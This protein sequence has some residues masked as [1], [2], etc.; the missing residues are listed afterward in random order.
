[1]LGAGISGL[2]AAH[3]LVELARDGGGPAALELA[4]FEAACR[5]G[6]IVATAHPDGL[7]LEDGPDA[8]ITDKPEALALCERIGLGPRLIATRP[9][10]RRSAVVFGRRLVPTPAGFHLLAPARLGPLLASP[11]LSLPGRLRAALEPWLPPRTRDGVADE[12]LASFVTRRLG[13]EVLERLAQP[14][15]G[16]IYGA[17]PEELSLLATFP[18]FLRLE[19][20]HG[21]VIRGLARSDRHARVA[22]SGPRY[23]LF[24][25]LQGGMQELADTLAARL[26]PG[27]LRLGT[28]VTGLSPVGMGGWTVVS[29][30]GESRFDAVVVAL[31]APAAGAL[32]AGFDAALG[33]ALGSLA[34]GSSAVVT[35]AFAAGDLGHPRDG[36]GF[37][38]PRRERMLALGGSFSDRKFEG[39]A[40]AGTA[41]VRVFFDGRSDGLDDRALAARAAAEAGALLQLRAG[42]APTSARVVR[43]PG[44]MPHYRVGH[45]A[46]V[47]AIAAR[48]GQWAGL[49]LAGNAYRGVGLPDCVRLGEAAAAAAWTGRG[50]ALPPARD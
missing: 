17:A 11:L 28:P 48:A 41:L 43:W 3:R 24:A 46:R 14:M 1:V 40:P 6:G 10:F 2:A 12:S 47:D 32:A 26:P 37:V 22:A 15:I 8:F 49:S 45:V 16:G 20:E 23:G 13:R 21:S 30:E 38:V 50:P 35:L 42:A 4:V 31:P 33:E 7:V 36:A 44:A 9:E 5:P 34:R 19:A 29:R 27:A 39:R 25:S 18:R